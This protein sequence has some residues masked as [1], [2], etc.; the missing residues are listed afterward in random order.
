MLHLHLHLQ[1]FH[2]LPSSFVPCT[3]RFVPQASNIIQH[4]TMILSTY[5]SLCL[6]GAPIPNIPSKNAVLER[7]PVT[8]VLV[9]QGGRC[10]NGRGASQQAGVTV[11]N[12]GERVTVSGPFPWDPFGVWRRPLTVLYSWTRVYV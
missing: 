8:G 7:R 9:A 2:A 6:R 5:L 1:R 12:V 11:T 4:E 3:R 10:A